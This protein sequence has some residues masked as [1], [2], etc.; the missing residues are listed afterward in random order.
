MDRLTYDFCV[1]GEHCWQVLG[2]DNKV[3]AE[4]CCEQEFCR[5]CP[6][7]R[8]IDKLAAY[9]DTGLEPEEI[10]AP[11]TLVRC[12]DCQHLTFSD[13]YG[14]C[15]AGHMGIVRPDDFCSYGVRKEVVS[16]GN[17]NDQGKCVH[18]RTQVD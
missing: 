8:A 11:A 1:N 7:G 14:E 9:E 10:K 2:A 6:I 16:D 12:K 17:E 18:G 4:V 13:C 3:C 5:D 15:G